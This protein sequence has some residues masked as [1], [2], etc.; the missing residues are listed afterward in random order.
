MHT[1]IDEAVAAFRWP[2]ATEN[3]PEFI[4]ELADIVIRVFDLAGAIDAR[5]FVM[6]ILLKMTKKQEKGN[7]AWKEILNL[8]PD[9]GSQRQARR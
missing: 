5:K 4:E 6:A 3:D 7:Q 2:E 1:E 9:A 8:K